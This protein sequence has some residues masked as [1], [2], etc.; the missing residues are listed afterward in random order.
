MAKRPAKG[1][2]AQKRERR[3]TRIMTKEGAFGVVVVA[4][5]LVGICGTL[6]AAPNLKLEPGKYA[7]TVTWEVQDQRQNEPTFTTRCITRQDLGYPERIFHYQTSSPPEKTET[8][9]VQNFKKADGRISYQADCSNRT[10]H[11]EGNLSHEAFSV[12]RTVMA[13]G[14]QEVSLKF[15]VSGR[16]TGDCS[17]P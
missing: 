4:A 17:K 3:A 16:R 1:S 12:V 8:C 14:N 7:V 5:A 13:K 6:G 9:S 10:V 15:I 2:P 11:V